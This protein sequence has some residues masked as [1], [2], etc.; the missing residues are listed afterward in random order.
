MSR[1]RHIQPDDPEP[2]AAAEEENPYDYRHYAA[3]A[4]EA[5]RRGA[6]ERALRYYGR[7]LEQDREQ[8]S[9]WLGQV[10]ALLRMG[11]PEEAQTW[12][13]QAAA[14]I[15][16]V[17]ALLALRAIAAVRAGAIEDARA[18][19][20][21]ALR[22]GADDPVVWLSRAEVLYASG[23]ERMAR[24]NLSKAHE[25]A[26]GAQTAL[27]CGD[28]ALSGGDLSGARPW[29]ERAA[30]EDLDSPVAALLLGIYWERAGDLERAKV[31]LSRALSLEPHS[32]A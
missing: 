19:S 4:E 9:A 11:Q 18:W 13:E 8:P 7:A 17:P 26:P 5:M 6:H 2:S 14:I 30:R 16:E 21:R 15:G 12:L 3:L 27:R 32:E 23:E 1:F 22:E 31:E 10:E 20:D 29:L 28:V 24:V 25:R